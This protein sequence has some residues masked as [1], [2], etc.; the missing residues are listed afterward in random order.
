LGVIR[1]NVVPLE[2]YEFNSLLRK[3]Y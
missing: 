3:R 1:F 2:I